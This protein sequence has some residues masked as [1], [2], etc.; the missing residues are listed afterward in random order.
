ML[1][2]LL[3]VVCTL[4]CL[5][6]RVVA[7]ASSPL[8]YRVEG[9]GIP[10]PLTAVPGNAQNGREV[11]LHPQRGNCLAC[12]RLPLPDAAIFSDIAPPLDTVGQRLSEAQLRLRLVDPKRLQPHTLMPAYYK[13]TDL[14]RV[15]PRYRERP[16]LQAQEVEDVVAYLL[17]LR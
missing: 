15:G 3:I 17:T 11:A 7:Q 16:I 6:H 14:H 5:P 12:H 9:D 4:G 1:A 2:R 8:T 13:L 10:Q